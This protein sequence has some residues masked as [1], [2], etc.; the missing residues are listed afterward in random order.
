M[1]ISASPRRLTPGQVANTTTLNVRTLI[2]PKNGAT[3]GSSL[4]TA[5]GTPA[6]GQQFFYALNLVRAW[7]GRINPATGIFLYTVAPGAA[8][9]ADFLN[10]FAAHLMRYHDVTC[11]ATA[12]TI[13]IISRNHGYTPNLVLENSSVAVTAV[14]TN[15]LPG[16][17]LL[18]G[19]VVGAYRGPGKERLAALPGSPL[20]GSLLPGNAQF[21]IVVEGAT[22]TTT[23][24]RR[25]EDVALEVAF[26]GTVG[27][28]LAG[29]AP[30]IPA[31]T[32]LLLGLTTS[33][34]A[35][36]FAVGTGD[37]TTGTISI[38]G[39]QGYSY[40]GTVFQPEDMFV[41]PGQVF[42]MRVSS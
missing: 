30:I 37:A 11:V 16:S 34:F 28:W 40:Q 42:P 9:L 12:T 2:Y 36:R 18:P 32:S 19:Q 23:N 38:G 20:F 6:Y 33:T 21:G 13:N 27:V 22:A 26:E 4:V 15:A 5:T 29:T 41:L 8:S 24:N 1:M 17:P 31:T 25:S 14:Q 3:Q 10:R 39:S 7:D 35:G